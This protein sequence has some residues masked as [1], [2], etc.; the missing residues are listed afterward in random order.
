MFLLPPQSAGL[1]L[2]PFLGRFLTQGAAGKDMF[3]ESQLGIISKNR[4]V[5]LELREN[6]LINGTHSCFLYIKPK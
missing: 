6:N 5:Y 1:L 2:V 3:A 4:R